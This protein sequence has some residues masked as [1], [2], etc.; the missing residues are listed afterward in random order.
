MCP[1]NAESICDEC[2][3]RLK[4]ELERAAVEL[5]ARHQEIDEMKV[6][7]PGFFDQVVDL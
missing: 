2:V 6:P 7:R 4:V 5:A 1:H 3:A